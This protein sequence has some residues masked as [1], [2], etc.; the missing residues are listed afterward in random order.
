MQEPSASSPD[1]A[2]IERYKY[3][4]ILKVDHESQ[5]DPPTDIDALPEVMVI[6]PLE[7]S[8]DETELMKI[9]PKFQVAL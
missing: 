9:D 3:L 1:P 2:F 8:K 5:V 6:G 4:T 7:L